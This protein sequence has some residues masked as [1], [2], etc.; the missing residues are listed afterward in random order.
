MSDVLKDD[1]LALHTGTA[2]S[3]AP[4]RARSEAKRTVDNL[5]EQ[6]IEQF[7]AAYPAYGLP[8][9]Y[10]GIAHAGVQLL[11]RDQILSSILH[12]LRPAR[13][14]NAEQPPPVRTA[15][16]SANIKGQK[17]SANQ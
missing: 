6:Q 17:S 14:A 9:L 16:K 2:D 4:V 8:A 3:S 15:E 12:V 7:Y 5:Y 10:G 13:S 11:N 1:M